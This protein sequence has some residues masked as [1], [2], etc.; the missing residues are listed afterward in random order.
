M[1]KIRTILAAAALIA[2]P[3]VL[4]VSPAPLAASAET[5]TMSACA[6]SGDCAS[7]PCDGGCDMPCAAK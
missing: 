4:A 7:L 2:A 6:P 5:C 1:M 3:S